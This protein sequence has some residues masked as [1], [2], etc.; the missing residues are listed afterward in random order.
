MYVLVSFL[1][2]LQVA[3]DW[4]EIIE[5]ACI[6][7]V[8]F[9]RNS[10]ITTNPIN[11]VNFSIGGNSVWPEME[12]VIRQY[13]NAG[14]LFVT[15]SGNWES[16][17]DVIYQ[18]P[19]FYASSLHSNPISGM[20]VAGRSDIND[21]RPFGAN[22]GAQTI[23]LYAPGQSI[24]STI[25]L[26]RCNASG[27]GCA[28]WGTHVAYGYHRYSGSSFSAPMVA[29]VAALLKAKYPFMNATAMKKVIL[30]GADS[31]TITVQNQNSDHVNMNVKRLNAYKAFESV[32]EDANDLLLKPRFN[33]NGKFVLIN[34]IDVRGVVQWTPIPQLGQTGILDG[35]NYSIVG[36][37]ITGRIVGNYEENYGL[38][39]RNRGTI[40]DLTLTGVNIYFEPDHRNVWTNVGAV[41]GI[42]EATGY[43]TNVHVSGNIEVHRYYSSMG[44]IVGTNYG[45]IYSCT[46]SSSQLKGNGDMGG[47][48]GANL[49]GGTIQA[50]NI[51]SS[52]IWHY[53]VIFNRSIGGIVGYSSLAKIMDCS[54]NATTIGNNGHDG[55]PNL[56]PFMGKIVGYLDNSTMWYVGADSSTVL[57][58][59]SLTG[60]QGQNQQTNFGMSPWW[61]WGGRMAGNCDIR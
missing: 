47:I 39:E 56:Q 25:P 27:I 2:P 42:N 58:P 12:T 54:V 51:F 32:I 37:P 3:N 8:I 21:A 57:N 26:N 11:I 38:F 43:I 36:L 35:N 41:A 49:S 29:G 4:G 10:M 16:D 14:G 44:G 40:R 19:S 20:L 50:A 13:S 18:Y 59:G 23:S 28:Q 9:A 6:R 15:A 60:P 30:A 34:S 53:Y 48:A 52:Q 33:P 17:N 45:G 22:W 5:A 24:T 7:A 55:T 46:L 61:D 31:I 1:V